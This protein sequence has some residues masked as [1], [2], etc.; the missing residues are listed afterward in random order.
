[1]VPSY[2]SLTLGAVLTI[3]LFVVASATDTPRQPRSCSADVR[4]PTRVRYCI[5]GAG[6]GGLQ[7][8][9]FMKRYGMDYLL[10]EAGPS[11]GQFF[12]RFP[13]QRNLISINK[14]Y[15]GTNDTEFNLRH[16][17]NSLLN[18]D[19]GYYFPTSATAA[20]AHDDNVQRSGTTTINAEPLWFKEFSQQYYPVADDI[21]KYVHAFADRH[22]I[23]IARGQT[24]KSIRRRVSPDAD[25]ADFYSFSI[26]TAATQPPSAPASTYHCNVVL[27]STGK[28]VPK[29]VHLKEGGHLLTTYADM[30]TNISR[31]RNKEILILG[32][33]N[34][35]FE[36]ARALESTTALIHIASRNPPQL[37][38]Q[39]HYVGDVRAVNLGF[40]DRYQL[41]S[42]DVLM[43]TASDD[44]NQGRLRYDNESGKIFLVAPGDL[45]SGGDELFPGRR[46]YDLVIACMGFKWDLS[47]FTNP[48]PAADCGSSEEESGAQITTQAAKTL[49]VRP[50]SD[51]TDVYAEVA[52]NYESVSVPGLYVAG[53]L[54][55]FRDHKFSAGGF[56]HG[57][58]YTIRHLVTHLREQY[59]GH[60]YPMIAMATPDEVATRMLFRLKNVSS[61]YQMQGVL[62]DV[63]L[64]DDPKKKTVVSGA[65]AQ[66]EAA[67]STRRYQYLQDIPLDHVKS[68][69]PMATNVKAMKPQQS[70]GD[71]A[72]AGDTHRQLFLTLSLEFGKDFQGVGVLHHQGQKETYKRRAEKIL[73]DRSSASEDP[74]VRRHLLHSGERKH[75]PLLRKPTA[76]ELKKNDPLA[77]Y[78]PESSKTTLLHPLHSTPVHIPGDE[79]GDPPKLDNYLFL[80]PVVRVWERNVTAGK[81]V[82]G[83]SALPTA[84]ASILQELRMHEDVLNDW[85][86]PLH[87]E[88]PLRRLLRRILDEGLLTGK[89]SDVP[90]VN[91]H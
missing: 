87:H 14:V 13:R 7:T 26:H 40:L 15:T 78:Q 30:P 42:M 75:L 71:A 50:M 64:F 20:S 25:E 85:T 56:I 52:S 57:F 34:S 35:A 28:A 19:D 23:H 90:I 12:T 41:K 81:P 21:V 49:R 68:R 5:V 58:R 43:S 89:S 22:Q 10:F 9:Y 29:S 54:M 8:A 62:C 88:R 17:W 16:D 1:M 47:P 32:A 67:A 66:A 24:V 79:P 27:L 84:T 39:T 11:P 38:Y 74:D 65:G 45:P 53:S 77:R 63:V 46:G 2:L 48:V 37:A 69:D 60:K 33:G 61:L 82:A 44:V 91:V 36:L 73:W 4:P 59:D 51:A 70:T 18:Q 76:K 6:P 3:A 83:T 55:H 86:G 31:Y 80:H 72:A